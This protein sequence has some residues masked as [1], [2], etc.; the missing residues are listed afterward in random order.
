MT[1]IVGSIT[2]YVG[3]SVGAYFLLCIVLTQILVGALGESVAEWTGLAAMAI[4][5][6]SIAC[7]LCH[8]FQKLSLGGYL[9]TGI[10]GLSFFLAIVH[11]LAPFVPALLETE[12]AWHELPTAA[13]LGILVWFALAPWAF[14][15]A[16]REAFD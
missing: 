14:A 10:L 11:W 2:N 12:T 13:R 5:L 3:A 15:T 4:L 1:R 8:R 9:L 16:T 7:S 6:A